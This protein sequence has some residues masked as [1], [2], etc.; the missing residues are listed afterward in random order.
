MQ[1]SERALDGSY[2][3]RFARDV[4]TVPGALCLP[5]IFLLGNG[6][7]SWHKSLVTFDCYKLKSICVPNLENAGKLVI[8]SSHILDIAHAKNVKFCSQRK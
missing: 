7:A 3:H 6:I 4:L 1:T 2:L 5:F 8:S